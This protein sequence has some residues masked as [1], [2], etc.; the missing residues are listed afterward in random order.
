[1]KKHHCFAYVLYLEIIFEHK[2]VIAKSLILALTFQNCLHKMER[3]ISRIPL[4]LKIRTAFLKK[5]VW[6]VLELVIQNCALTYVNI[7]WNEIEF[8]LN[9]T[10]ILYLVLTLP[11]LTIS[12][13]AMIFQ[14]YVR[15]LK[16]NQMLWRGSSSYEKCEIQQQSG[17]LKNKF[18][19]IQKP[20]F[21]VSIFPTSE[22]IFTL[23]VSFLTKSFFI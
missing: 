11:R 7:L 16:V 21:L 18:L 4:L 17:Q 19:C 20:I 12:I 22:F 15:S 23:Q 10:Y 2:N 13:K 1:M 14:L 6:E 9:R 3:K 8:W 5:Y